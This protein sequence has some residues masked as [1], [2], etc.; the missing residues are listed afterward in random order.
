MSTRASDKLKALEQYGHSMGSIPH[1]AIGGNPVPDNMH[2]WERYRDA[3][4][5]I[6]AAV[7]ALEKIRDVDPLTPQA[8]N[9]SELAR[10]ALLPLEGALDA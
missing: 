2:A 9:M 8:R 4:P 7:E 5:Q 3:L 6:R 10:Y 1:Y